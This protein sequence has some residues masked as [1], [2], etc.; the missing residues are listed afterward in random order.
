MSQFSTAPHPVTFLG[1]PLYVG[2]Q[3]SMLDDSGRIRRDLGI[4][5]AVQHA[6]DVEP[7]WHES[8]LLFLFSYS[9]NHE[10]F[11]GEMVRE[12]SR[13]IVASPPHLRAWGGI[14]LAGAKRG[15]IS[16]A[17]YIQVHNPDAHRANATLWR[18]LIYR[19]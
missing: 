7:G 8:A 18:S 17:G 1:R 3:L 6:E 10:T 9:G 19:G 13:D 5:H 12:A 11:S 14:M 16:R 2:E 4:R 15:W